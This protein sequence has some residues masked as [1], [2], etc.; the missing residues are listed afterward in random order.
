MCV[1]VCVCARCVCACALCV[2][3]SVCVC[4][5][6]R[7]CMCGV[8]RGVVVCG[9]ACGWVVPSFNPTY[10]EKPAGKST[11]PATRYLG[12]P[13]SGEQHFKEPLAAQSAVPLRPLSTLTIHD[14]PVPAVAIMS[15]PRCRPANNPT[16][17]DVCAPGA[18]RSSRKLAVETCCR[19]LKQNT[20][21]ENAP[22]LLTQPE[23]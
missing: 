12:T 9:W 1:C 2:C 17:R 20:A 7:V 8:A 4:V 13:S 3:V 18:P 22:A 11:G 5:C 14:L 15:S 10:A 23:I 19:R 21:I 6:A 16:G